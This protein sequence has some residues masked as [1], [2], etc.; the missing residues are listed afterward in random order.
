VA[1][2]VY[3]YSSVVTFGGCGDALLLAVSGRH[4]ANRSEAENLQL[5]MSKPNVSI[6]TQ[7]VCSFFH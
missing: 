2:S 3:D 6:H 5:L 1:Y 4:C 7:L